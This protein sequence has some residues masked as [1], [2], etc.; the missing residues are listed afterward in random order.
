MIQKYKV[1][2]FVLVIACSGNGYADGVRRVSN[3]ELRDFTQIVEAGNRLDVI[4]ASREVFNEGDFL[5]DGYQFI[6]SPYRAGTD[7]E[8]TEYIFWDE[9]ALGNIHWRTSVKVKKVDGEI[10]EFYAGAQKEVSESK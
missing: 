8:V 6:L 9:E 2:L 3:Q 7:F 4:K 5:V 10:M 1:L